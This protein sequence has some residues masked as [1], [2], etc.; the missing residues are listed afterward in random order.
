[1]HRDVKPRNGE[2]FW[3]F[4]C[5]RSSQRLLA[6]IPPSY[7]S[8]CACFSVGFK[9]SGTR[10][11][12]DNSATIPRW[13]SRSTAPRSCNRAKVDANRPWSSRFLHT[14]H[15]IQCTRSVAPLQKP[16]ALDWI[17]ILPLLN[18]SLANWLHLSWA[19]VSEGAILSRVRSNLVLVF[20]MSV[21]H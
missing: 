13:A 20:K 18:G 5:G 12:S 1:M 15:K 21:K 11:H 16:R 9:R 14:R 8:S 19:S 7:T 2:F 17:S 6:M 10:N 3:L 4:D